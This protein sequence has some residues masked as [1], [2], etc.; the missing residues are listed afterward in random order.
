MTASQKKRL[1]ALEQQLGQTIPL[2]EF[3][4]FMCDLYTEV[5]EN[6][7]PVTAARIGDRLLEIMYSIGFYDP[8]EAPQR[9]P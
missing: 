6:C 5:M 2:S 1:D 7:D 4:A 8:P 9:Q 3:Q